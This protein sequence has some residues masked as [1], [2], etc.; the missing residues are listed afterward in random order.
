MTRLRV[1]YVPLTDAAPLIVA[2][3]IGFAAEEGLT[4]DLQR[5]QSWAQA[6]D[7]LGAGAVDAAHMLVPMPIAQALG[8]GPAYRFMTTSTSRSPRCS[9]ARKPA[10]SATTGSCKTSTSCR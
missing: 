1:G 9:A 7:L 10:L 3:E 5:L 4:L 6:R 8:L 2:H